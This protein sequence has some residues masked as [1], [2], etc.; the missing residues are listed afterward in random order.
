M[1]RGP[2]P[3]DELPVVPLLPGI[4]QQAVDEDEEEDDIRCATPRGPHEAMIP[5]THNKT[6]AKKAQRAPLRKELGVHCSSQGGL[7]LALGRVP[8]R[9]PGCTQQHSVWATQVHDTSRA[10]FLQLRSLSLSHSPWAS[11]NQTTPIQ[12]EGTALPKRPRKDAFAPFSL[13]C[14]TGDILQPGRGQLFAARTADRGCCIDPA[15]GSA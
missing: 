13:R 1:T 4:S 15:N 6:L 14:C 7:L 2:A 3:V 9:M 12:V 5:H 8:K 10:R 11:S